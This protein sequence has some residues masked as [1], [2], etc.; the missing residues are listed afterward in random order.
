MATIRIDGETLRI[1]LSGWDKFWTVHG[2]FAIPLANVAGASTEKPPGFWEALKLIGT[3]SPWP[4]TM[5]GT[6]LYHRETVFFD[7][8]ADDAV[9]VVD[10]VPGASA[11]RHL[12]VH[13]DDPDTP[14]AAAQRI[15]AALTQS[16]VQTPAST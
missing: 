12:F 14:A 7:Y 6:F 15:D 10:L 4:F 2:S 5:K 9:V 8:R 16:S 3:A 1:E 13:V 11:Y